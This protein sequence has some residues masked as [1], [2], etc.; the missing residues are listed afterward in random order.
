MLYYSCPKTYTYS[1]KNVDGRVAVRAPYYGHG[2]VSN[3]KKL[4]LSSKV[5]REPVIYISWV[6]SGY[7]TISFS[8]NV[9]VKHV[10]MKIS[11]NFDG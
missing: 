1:L 9:T 11:H 3:K 10:R 2:S 6:P 7:A 4:A 5:P 8:E